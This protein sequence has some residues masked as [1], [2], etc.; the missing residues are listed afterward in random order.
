MKKLLLA[1]A[2]VVAFGV[3]FALAQAPSPIPQAQIVNPNDLIQDIPNGLPSAQN[4]YVKPA[5]ITSQ[6]GYAKYSPVTGFS[7]TFGNSQSFIVLTNS[8]TLALGTIT[9]AAAPSD[10][11]KECIY[12]QNTITTFGVFANTGQTIDNAVTTLS[13][14]TSACYLYSLSNTTWDRD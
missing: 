9:L 13:A 14:A 7:Y 12:A 2:S 3:T 4:Y 1:S 5:Q 10:G 8:T 6:S 11:A